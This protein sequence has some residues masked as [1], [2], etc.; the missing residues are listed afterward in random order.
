DRMLNE[1]L[2]MKEVIENI[3]CQ[4]CGGPPLLEEEH[5]SFMR[6]MQLQNTMLKEE[7]GE[8]V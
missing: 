3:I 1:N 7:V 8:S 2:Q 4:D 5:E 6:Q